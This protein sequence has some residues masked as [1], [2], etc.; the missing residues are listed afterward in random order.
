MFLLIDNESGSPPSLAKININTLEYTVILSNITED[1]NIGGS[2]HAYQSVFS[3]TTDESAVVFG[4]L[5]E[6][7]TE[8]FYVV[9]YT[10]STKEIQ[11]SSFQQG[12]PQDLN[13]L[14]SLNGEF[15]FVL[16]T[17][18]ELTQYT[19]MWDFGSLIEVGSLVKFNYTNNLQVSAITNSSVFFT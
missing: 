15:G 11:R 17:S 9:R 19:Q 6:T 5:S 3:V 8:G 14:R 16:W 13:M 7:S 18:E 4:F 12:V 10:F 1:L 2:L